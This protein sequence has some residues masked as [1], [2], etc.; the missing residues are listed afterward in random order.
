MYLGG[1][2]FMMFL[3]LTMLLQHRDHI[4]KNQMDYNETAMYFDKMVRKH[5]VV[6]VLAQAR[7][8]YSNYL[9]Q[10]MIPKA[11]SRMDERI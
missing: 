9:K 7:Q 3:C 6:R 1:N 2:P 10:T 4:M 11:A 8:M 5:N